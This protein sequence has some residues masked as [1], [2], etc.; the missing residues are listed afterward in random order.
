MGM[1]LEALW[2][3]K[4]EITFFSLYAIA[5]ACIAFNLLHDYSIG[6]HDWK[7]ADWLINNESGLVRRGFVGS[8]L[9]SVSDLTSADLLALTIGLQLVLLLLVVGVTVLAA[10]RVGLSDRLALLLMSPGFFVVFWAGDPSASLRKEIFVFGAFAILALAAGSQG[11]SGGWLFL[12]VLLFGIS[13]TAHE[14]MIFFLP[15]FLI[16][17]HYC[18]DEKIDKF[19][20]SVMGGAA[21]LAIVPFLVNLAFPKIDDSFL[22]C[23]PLLERGFSLRICDGAISSLTRSLSDE[24]GRTSLLFLSFAPF[25]LAISVGLVALPIGVFLYGVSGLSVRVIALV[26]LVAVISFLPLYLVAIDWGRWLSFQC[27]A[28]TFLALILRAKGVIVESRSSLSGATFMA[29][30]LFVILFGFKIADA[31]PLHGGLI[32]EFVMGDFEAEGHRALANSSPSI[33]GNPAK[34]VE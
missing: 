16:A 22:V 29:M 31:N 10:V 26:M 27:T 11:R 8:L 30:F 6:G 9:L 4:V 32:F 28:V 15:A 12:A 33:S 7:Q 18:L 3:C 19:Y 5:T 1:T 17:L 13:V 34:W 23:Q 2:R 25:K 20:G 24:I 14:G 21:V